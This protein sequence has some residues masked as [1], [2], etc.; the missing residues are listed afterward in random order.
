VVRLGGHGWLF[1]EI[2]RYCSTVVGDMCVLV[3]A[4]VLLTR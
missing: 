2:W 1:A 3:E 4:S